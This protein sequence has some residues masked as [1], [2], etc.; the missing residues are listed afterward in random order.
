MDQLQIEAG[1]GLALTACKWETAKLP[2]AVVQVAHGAAEHL[3]RYDRLAR[4]L[5][6]AGYAVL[7][8][9]HR[10]HGVNCLHGPGDFGPR[11]FAGVVD[12][13]RAVAEAGRARHPGLPLVLFG[14]S[15]GSFAAQAFFAHHADLIDGLVLSGTAAI[16]ELIASGDL[17]SGFEACN[18]AFE[19]ARTPFDWLSR[20]AAEVDA[21]MADPLCGVD[22]KLTSL[23]SMPAT[24]AGVRSAERLSTAVARQVP[25]YVISGAD[26]P[27]VGPDQR[28]ARAVV[29][30]YRAAGLRDIE[31]KIYVGGRHE[32]I[33]ETNREEVTR[34][35]VRWLDARFSAA[36]SSTPAE[37]R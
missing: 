26:D 16:D 3:G 8:S 34:D 32:M 33:N 37:F 23:A 11:G 27:I 22:L 28:N 19:P 31:H 21:Y 36:A 5:N 29:D 2:K 25:V 17:T 15:M 6:R 13:L 14:H 35:L 10:G 30:S 12:D 7:G 20:D 18:A 24:V 4:D 9:D 1:D